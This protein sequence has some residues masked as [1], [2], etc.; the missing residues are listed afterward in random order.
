[1][2]NFKTLEIMNLEN[3][4]VSSL[5]SNEITETEGGWI[6]EAIGF[7]LGILC[8]DWDAAG[9]DYVRGANSVK[10]VKLKYYQ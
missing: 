6:K 7:A 4:N 10:L 3:L 5:S 2:F 1:M 9:N 8:T